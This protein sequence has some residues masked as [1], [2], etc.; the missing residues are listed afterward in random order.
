MGSPKWN[1]AEVD[2]SDCGCL[3]QRHG[4]MPLFIC[5]THVRD[6]EGPEGYFRLRGPDG[7]LLMIQGPLPIELAGTEDRT[8]RAQATLDALANLVRASMPGAVREAFS[9]LLSDLIGQLRDGARRDNFSRG[10]WAGWTS[11]AVQLQR[12]IDE[13]R[14]TD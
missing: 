5:M 8:E 13:A 6:V 11:L 4:G 9:G 10:V 14:H 7:I 1:T 3:R 12:R 2:R